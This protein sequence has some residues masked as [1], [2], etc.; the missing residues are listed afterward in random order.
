VVLV[1]LGSASLALWIQCFRKFGF[2]LDL[3]VPQR[4]RS[5]PFWTAGDPLIMFGLMLFLS[6][7]IQFAF[8]AAGL[9]QLPKPET[10]PSVDPPSS[11]ETTS[12]QVAAIWASVCAGG[13]AMALM[14]TWLRSRFRYQQNSQSEPNQ[15]AVAEN[16]DSLAARLG[17]PIN[18]GDVGLGLKAALMI[19]PPV[20]LISAGLSFVVPYEHPVLD[21]L[22]GLDAPFRLAGIFVCTAIVTPVV[23]EFLFRGL[24]IGG[25]E[26]LVTGP[27]FVESE[28]NRWQPTSPWPI[29]ISSFLFAIMHFG[30]GAAP[31]PL[32][33]LALALGYLYQRTGSLTAPIVVHMVLNSLTL[34]VEI[35]QN[36]F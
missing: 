36:N 34:I 1:I 32:F 26:R 22:K 28:D 12:N 7:I 17:L 14:I 10:L 19:L 2:K 35:A 33:V 25:L 15:S 18:F 31:V 16:N 21:V 29:L 5:L 24:M 27:D 11:N 30:Q 9:I 4:P 6:G 20:L 8:V 13:A 23:E 3:L